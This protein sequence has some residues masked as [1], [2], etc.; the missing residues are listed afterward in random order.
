MSYTDKINLDEP[1]LRVD[2]AVARQTRS[3]IAAFRDIVCETAWHF[4]T[5]GVTA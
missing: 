5:V 2:R 3:E 1:R 4:V